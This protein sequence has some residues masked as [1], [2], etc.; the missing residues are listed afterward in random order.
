MDIPSTQKSSKWE[1]DEKQ[2]VTDK[3]VVNQMQEKD[4]WI[5]EQDKKFGTTQNTLD[6]K[7][8]NFTAFAGLR[9]EKSK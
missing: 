9:D 7:D 3:D 6:A 4:N 8:A 5:K 2:D 1:K